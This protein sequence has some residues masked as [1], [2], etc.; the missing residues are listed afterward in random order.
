MFN[1]F[2][3][4]NYQTLSASEFVRK[5]QEEPGVVLDVRT[6]GEY[7]GGHLK[8]AKNLDLMGGQFAAAIAK[9]DKSKTYYLYCASGGRSGS[10]AG[11]MASNG[12]EHVYN[13]GGYMSLVAAGAK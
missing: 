10:A 9:L 5:V 1:I 8:H 6:P 2:A 12:F 11:M 4:K 3:K 13:V 7:A